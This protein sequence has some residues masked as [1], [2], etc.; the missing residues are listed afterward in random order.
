MVKFVNKFRLILQRITQRSKM[1]SFKRFIAEDSNPGDTHDYHHTSY[2]KIDIN[3]HNAGKGKNPNHPVWLSH[4]SHQAD[5]WHRNTHQETGQAHTYRVKVH[6]NIAHHKDEKVKALF[7]KH[8]HDMD[9]YHNHLV[10][11]PDHN[12]VHGHPATKMLQKA[13]YHGHTH[14]DYDPHN[15]QRDH[16]STVVFHRKHT[17]MQD[18]NAKPK[19]EHEDTTHKVGPHTVTHKTHDEYM[20][21]SRRPLSHGGTESRVTMSHDHAQQLKSRLKGSGQKVNITKGKKT[22]R[23]KV[24]HRDGIDRTNFHHHI[25]QVK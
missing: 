12:E 11:N 16:D 15:F 20:D 25:M 4:N 22:S 6:G 17:T 8:G 21:G 14:P 3:K 18:R 10:G 9:R 24:T 19:H 1:L 7:K 2:N 13:G 23:V 5:G